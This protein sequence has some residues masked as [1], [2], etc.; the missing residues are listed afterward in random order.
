VF[1]MAAP[2][3]NYCQINGQLVNNELERIWKEILVAYDFLIT[4]YY[5]Y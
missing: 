4:V 3:Q 1:E 2:I 5:L